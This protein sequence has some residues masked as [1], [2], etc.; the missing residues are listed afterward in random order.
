VANGFFASVSGSEGNVL[1]CIEFDS[2]KNPIG[3]AGGI[4]G[5]NGIKENTF[6][7]AHEGQLKE[8]IEID[9]LKSI[10]LSKRGNVMKVLMRDFTIQ[11]VVTDGTN[12]AHGETLKQAKEALKYKISKRDLS[13]FENLTTKSVLSYKEALVC[14]RSITGACESGINSWLK[15][16]GIDEKDYKIF[17]MINLTKNAYGGDIFANFFKNK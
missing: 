6:Y 10:L 12:L 17:E 15:S 13:E 1:A 2:D 16:Q 9:G 7:C 8:L 5:Q 3:F 14:Y 11:Y 4:V